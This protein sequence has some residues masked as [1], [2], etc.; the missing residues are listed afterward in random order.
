MKKTKVLILVFLT[1]TMIFTACKKGEDSSDAYGNF[2]ADEV[3]V[4][5]ESA[6]KILQMNVN[7]GDKVKKGQELA[8]VDTTSVVLSIAQLKAQQEAT[9]MGMA[10]INAQVVVLNEQ[11]KNLLTEQARLEK[12][13]ET[14]AAPAQ[15]L[16]Q[17]N[18]Q[19]AVTEAKI[20]A[21]EASKVKITG[22]LGVIRKKLENLQNQ[23][24]HCFIKSPAEGTILEVFAEAGEMTAPGKPLLKFANLDELNLKVY[25]SGDQLTDVKIGDEV[26]VLID[27]SKKENRVV[28]GKIS[29]V[30]SEAEFTPKIIQTKEERVNLVYAVKVR[31]KNDGSIK[32]GMPGE[33]KM[34]NN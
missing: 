26:D 14:H 2:E 13:L 34:V 19:I 28:K 31:I 20:N 16:D 18:G 22:E 21:T 12:L 25:I 17:I 11:K 29:W 6:G 15:K 30:S 3:L 32:I 23:F 27:E 10:T 7:E 1:S 8:V 4:S 24:N 5:A 33:M 9:Q